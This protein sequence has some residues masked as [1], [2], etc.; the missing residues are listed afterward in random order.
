[1]P[2]KDGRVGFGVV[3][4]NFGLGRCKA[5]Q[6]VPEAELVAVASRTEETARRVGAELGVEAYADYRRLLDRDDVDVVCIFTPN[7]FHRDIAVGAAQAGKHLVVTKPLE[8][9]LERVD[10][11]IE[12]A[13]ANGVKLATEYMERFKPGHYLGYQAIADGSLGRLV[14]GEFAYKCF[15]PQAYY[16]GTRGTWAVDGGGVMLLQAIHSL[17]VMLWY[18]G[19]V[20]SVMARSG[21]LTHEMESEDTAMSIVTFTSGAIATLVGTTTFH[22]DRPGGQYG[23][24]SMT[25]IEVGGDKGSLIL[26]DGNVAMWKSLEAETPPEAKLPALNTFEDMARWVRDDTYE[27]PTLV[28]AA[29]SRRAIELIHA[30]YESAKSGKVITL[31][32]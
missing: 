30:I 5:I 4:L 12:A 27:S 6:A 29:D 21:T 24:G 25:R 22:N 19:P 3:G 20:Q 23:G 11:I 7:A 8:I 31:S 2:T 1:M 10:A 9:T 32:A 13:E 17:D 14:T 28:K 18:M 16:T 26:T 15:R